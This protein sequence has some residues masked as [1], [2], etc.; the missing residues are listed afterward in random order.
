[1]RASYLALALTMTNAAAAPVAHYEIRVT[2]ES[3]AGSP[4]CMTGVVLFGCV[5]VGDVYF[6]QFQ[7][8][9]STLAVN[10]YSHNLQDFEFWLNF[11]DRYYSTGPDN[12]DLV[13]FRGGPTYSFAPTPS[14]FVEDGEVE[15]LRGGV[16][17]LGDVPYVD[18]FVPT[19]AGGP[20]RFEARDLVQTVQGRIDLRRIP[21]PSTIALTLVGLALLAGI[22]SFVPRVS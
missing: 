17:A 1:M 18:F 20:G 6:G 22:G 3:V 4:T 13:G 9:A 11:E 12:R 10:G 21:I 19:S 7:V 2:V 16:Y 8:A 5:S 14:I 15:F